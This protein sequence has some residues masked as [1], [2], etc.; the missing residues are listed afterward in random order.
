MEIGKIAWPTVCDDVLSVD[1]APQAD[2][3]HAS[4]FRLH[5]SARR[6]QKARL[7]DHPL[8]HTRTDVHGHHMTMEPPVKRPRTSPPPTADFVALTASDD[9]EE[10]ADHRFG[11]TESASPPITDPPD[12]G[13]AAHQSYPRKSRRDRTYLSSPRFLRLHA[14]DRPASAHA[15]P[16]HEGWLMVKTKLG[17]RFVHD[18][19]TNESLWFVPESL[20]PAVK[21]WEEGERTEGEKKGNAAWA[22]R[23][24]GRMRGVGAVNGKGVAEGAGVK[25][26]AD[27]GV[28]VG[29]EVTRRRR[30]SESLQREDEEAVMAEL[31]AVA[32]AQEANVGARAGAGGSAV[33]TLEPV[34]GDTGY[35]SEGSYEYVEVT[36]HEGE[37]DDEQNRD[38]DADG[39]AE[40]DGAMQD[41]GPVEFGEDDIAYQLAAM[42]EEYGLDPE[43]YGGDMLPP[44]GEDE[45]DDWPADSG[46]PISPEEAADLFRDLLD[47]HAISPFTPWDQLLADA[48]P[49][50]IVHDDRYTVLP[51]TR[52]RKQVF[53]TWVRDRSAALRDERA[54]IEKRDPRIPYL[55]FLG[56]KASPKLYWPEFKRKFKKDAVMNDRQ[57]GDKERERLYREHVTRL[58][59]PESTRRADLVLLLRSTPPRDLHRGSTLET[60]PQQVLGHLHYISL[61][62]ALRD[63]VITGHISS[64]PPAPSGGDEGEPDIEGDRRRAERR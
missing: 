4:S 10:A 59:L 32:Q 25:E 35:D 54:Q 17:R 16:G 63:Q 37:E 12:D 43:D 28:G 21:A 50:G 46:L 1:A 2:G 53:D 13:T 29:S 55:A 60:L 27:V 61:P 30:R 62:A 49:A 64:L 9:D 19:R 18:T 36:D 3:A 45:M 44:D 6:T 31:A 34:V 38:A 41:E 15:L 26:G 7:A 42:G 58:K 33:K 47:D 40:Q 52:A 56:E 51:T 11:Y 8:V 5:D 20:W 39:V 48:S 24:L 22:E 57:L 14:R 23:E